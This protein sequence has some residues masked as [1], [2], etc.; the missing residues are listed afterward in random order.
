LNRVGL[1]DHW[2]NQL[3]LG[4]SRVLTVT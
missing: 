2:L 3:K 4:L 1:D